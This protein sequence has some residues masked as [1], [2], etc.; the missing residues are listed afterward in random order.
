MKDEKS[1]RSGHG[2]RVAKKAVEVAPRKKA[3]EDGTNGEDI[4]L[5]RKREKE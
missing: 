1:K 5:D 4:G 3:V 2:R